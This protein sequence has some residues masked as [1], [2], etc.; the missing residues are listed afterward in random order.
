M[1]QNFNPKNPFQ[2]IKLKKKIQGTLNTQFHSKNLQLK[3]VT[4]IYI[5]INKHNSFTKLK[6]NSKK[7]KLTVPL[8]KQKTQ[9]Q[10]QNEF[11]NSNSKLHS[12]NAKTN[13]SF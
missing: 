12:G 8:Q 1:T 5:N 9:C 10:T 7:L 4:E 11:K 6:T 13:S 3:I 2:A